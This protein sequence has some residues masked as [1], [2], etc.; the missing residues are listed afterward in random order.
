MARN[1]RM[2]GAAKA[3][4]GIILSAVLAWLTTVG[5]LRHWPIWE[6]LTIVGPLAVVAAFLMVWGVKG[7]ESFH[8]QRRYL[9]REAGPILSLPDIHSKKFPMV[10]QWMDEAYMLANRKRGPAAAERIRVAGTG[11]G[12]PADAMR[13][14][15]DALRGLPRWRRGVKAN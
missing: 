1:D 7:G 11:M 14:T 15:V 12:S 2:Q 9:L 10:F 13:S 5:F 8:A 3:I 6:Q 4:S